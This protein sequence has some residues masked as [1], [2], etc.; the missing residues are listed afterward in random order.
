[1]GGIWLSKLQMQMSLDPA[2]PLL[3]IY[4]LD[5]NVKR[6]M[7]KV[8]SATLQLKEMEII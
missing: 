5:I 6:F 3:G 2:E 8:F 4:L 7:T 1:M